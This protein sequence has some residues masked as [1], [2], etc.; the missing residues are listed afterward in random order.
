MSLIEVKDLVK[1]YK[2]IEKED[3]LFGYF[4][5]LVKPK[6]SEIMAVKGV[7]FNIEEGELVGYI[8]ENG[9]GKS[10]TIKMLTRT[11]NPNFWKC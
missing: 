2:I 11:I 1:T 7:N 6:Y 8:G 4:K 10:T 5:N 9:A 3:G